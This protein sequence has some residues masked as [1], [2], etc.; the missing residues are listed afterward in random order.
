M[1][2]GTQKA[3]QGGDVLVRRLDRDR[4]QD[5]VGRR[6]GGID[7]KTHIPGAYEEGRTGTASYLVRTG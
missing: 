5:S 3:G 4:R 7:A 1:H 6:E 2:L